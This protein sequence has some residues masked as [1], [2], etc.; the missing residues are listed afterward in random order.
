MVKAHLELSLHFDCYSFTVFCQSHQE[1]LR[2]LHLENIKKI[3]GAWGELVNVMREHLG[4]T[5]IKLEG[6]ADKYAVT[7]RQL[8]ENR[9]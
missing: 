6:L 2:S 9:F 7:W 1:S 5:N 3:G 4:L 8:S